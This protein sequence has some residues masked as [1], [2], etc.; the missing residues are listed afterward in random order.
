MAPAKADSKDVQLGVMDDA[1]V[2]DRDASESSVVDDATLAID[3]DP[4]HIMV[5]E[6]HTIMRR[7]AHW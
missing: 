4:D 6:D 7:S 5:L 2:V 1:K 3:T